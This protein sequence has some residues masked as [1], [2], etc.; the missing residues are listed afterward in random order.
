MGNLGHPLEDTLQ[1]YGQ[2]QKAV[3]WFGNPY[4][5]W[6]DRQVPGG[7]W[8]QELI[9]RA[10]GS[11][12]IQSMVF[13][14][15][16]R[17]PIAG[18]P[19]EHLQIAPTQAGSFLK[20]LL[21]LLNYFG[22]CTSNPDC[23]SPVATTI[24][25]TAA[26]SWTFT[27][28][29]TDEPAINQL[30]IEIRDALSRADLMVLDGN[31]REDFIEELTV[32]Y[33]GRDRYHEQL[34]LTRSSNTIKYCRQAVDGP[35]ITTT[36]QWPANTMSLLDNL[37]PV[38]FTTTIPGLPANAT[39]DN[40]QF[41]HFQCTITRR[42]LPAISF[43]GDYEQYRLPAPWADLMQT[44]EDLIDVPAMGSL[45]NPRCYL[46]KR[47][48]LDEVIYIGVTFFDDGHE[49]HY[50]TDDDSIQPG[51][52]VLVPVGVSN[53]EQVRTVTSKHYYKRDEV[54]YPLAKIKKVIKKVN[55]AGNDSPA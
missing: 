2:T 6:H 33:T 36:F 31:S 44:V 24:E 25:N 26:D 55:P 17:L 51:D 29:P 41:G 22:T 1:K 5:P 11:C 32:H 15:H 8:G 47:R 49:Y 27:D 48:C 45:L 10:D 54:P 50:L 39:D 40:G 9:I 16:Q 13:N 3:L 21:V 28:Y 20:R 34:T 42:T 7:K 52:D 43:A 23:F 19:T 4:L 37:N 18:Q 38:E 14:D 12:T 53:D 46:R 35:A 30:A